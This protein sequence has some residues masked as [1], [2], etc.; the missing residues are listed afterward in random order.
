MAVK[1][2]QQCHVMNEQKKKRAHNERILQIDH[3]T[4]TLLV[5][6]INGSMGNEYQFILAFGT[7]DM[8][9]LLKSIS[10]DW[11]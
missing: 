4:F 5:L 1:S 2:L 3:G 11:I 10:I 9:D 6:S 7:N 8:R